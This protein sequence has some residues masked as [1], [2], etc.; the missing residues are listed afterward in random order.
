MRAPLL[1]AALALAAC[2]QA[3]SGFDDPC[4]QMSTAAARR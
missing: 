2:S 3:P 1:A 4:A